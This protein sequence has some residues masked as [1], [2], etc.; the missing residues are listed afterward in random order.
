MTW[1]APAS[2]N[3][4]ARRVIMKCRLEVRHTLP[5]VLIRGAEI[6][7]CQVEFGSSWHVLTRVIAHRPVDAGSRL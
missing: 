6:G 2:C 1:Q 5:E 7:V 3:L 4:A